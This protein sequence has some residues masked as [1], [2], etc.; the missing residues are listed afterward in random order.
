VAKQSRLIF[1]RRLAKCLDGSWVI[2]TTW[3]LTEVQLF[4]ASEDGFLI[5]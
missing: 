4:Y 3:L 1:Q 2:L 5:I